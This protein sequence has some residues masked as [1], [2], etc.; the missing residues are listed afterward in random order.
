M[1]DRAARADASLSELAGS[2][3]A[4][5]DPEAAAAVTRTQSHVDQAMSG[6]KRD[7]QSR[8]AASQPG[9]RQPKPAGKP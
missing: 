5:G 8:G 3:V 2:L 7:L 6:S 9:D 4:R 1:E